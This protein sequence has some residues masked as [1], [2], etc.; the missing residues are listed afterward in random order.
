[1]VPSRGRTLSPPPG[2][3][4]SRGAARRRG[5]CAGGARVA[6][7]GLRRPL[8]EAVGREPRLDQRDHDQHRR[9][10]AGAPAG[11][12]PVPGRRR[13]ELAH[14]EGRL[15]PAPPSRAACASTASPTSPTRT[16]RGKSRFGSSD[17]IDP[18]SPQFQA[19]QKACQK[20]L[21]NG[22]VPT[23]AQLAQA[24][25]AML[26]YS[27]CMR[28]HGVPK[29]PRPELLGR[30]CLAQHRL[31]QRD[32][33]AVGAVPVGP[34]GLPERSSRPPARRRLEWR[35]DETDIERRELERERRLRA[36]PGS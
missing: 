22:G 16:A 36:S 29:L 2:G 8:A 18:S 24:Q 35:R 7:R 9:A 17:G 14:D 5:R 30:P 23:P 26:K 4:R 13:R 11:G 28:S 12:T 25:T 19:A 32:R 1:M 10:P 33:P 20:V 15:A 34:D 31:R 3:R 6:R 21:P 27:A